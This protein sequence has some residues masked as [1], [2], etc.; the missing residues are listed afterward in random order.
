MFHKILG[1]LMLG[2]LYMLQISYRVSQ[3]K[4]GGTQEWNLFVCREWEKVKVEWIENVK[5]EQTDFL[6]KLFDTV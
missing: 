3:K 6:F 1:G 5:L 2:H 4:N